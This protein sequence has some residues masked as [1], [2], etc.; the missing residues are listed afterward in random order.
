MTEYGSELMAQGMGNYYQLKSNKYIINSQLLGFIGSQQNVEA[1]H[2]R[3]N[4][5]KSGCH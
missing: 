1:V 4:P 2:A 3:C 5:A